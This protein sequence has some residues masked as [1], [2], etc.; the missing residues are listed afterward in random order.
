MKRLS[1]Y[2]GEEAIEL[3]ADLLEPLT[4]IL[5]DKE[6]AK[7]IQ[8][9]KPKTLWAKEILRLHKSDAEQILLRID[10][11]PL[12]GLNILTRLLA[13]VVDIGENEDIKPFF[14]SAVQA[15]QTSDVFS[16]NA[17]ESTEGAEN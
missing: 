14:V 7:I 13:I 12:D 6:I 16:G 4:A 8:S 1:E 17:T 15:E 3:W 2:K 11:T 5:G 9:G 10:P